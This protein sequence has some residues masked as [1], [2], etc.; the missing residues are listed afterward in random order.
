M[1]PHRSTLVLAGLFTATTL[2][3]VWLYAATSGPLS[4][5]AL[6]LLSFCGK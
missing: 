5:T 6:S 4:F 3:G 1:K 2:L